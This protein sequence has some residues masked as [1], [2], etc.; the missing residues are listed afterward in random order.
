MH[1]QSQLA[2]F[3]PPENE[4]LVDHDFLAL[5][6]GQI[7]IAHRNGDISMNLD[8]VFRCVIVIPHLHPFLQGKSGVLGKVLVAADEIR[9]GAGS[10]VPKGILAERQGWFEENL[11]IFIVVEVVDDLTRQSLVV[12]AFLVDL[13]DL[14]QPVAPRLL[15]GV[16]FSFRDRSARGRVGRENMK[17]DR[18]AVITTAAANVPMGNGVIALRILLTLPDRFVVRLCEFVHWQGQPQGTA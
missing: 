4:G 16:D 9:K 13:A 12:A 14:D 6:V 8:A 1:T 2:V 7:D 18:P 17:A 5:G 15:G 10:R 11:A 3:A